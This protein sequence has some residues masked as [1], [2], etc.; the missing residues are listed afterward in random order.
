M[1]RNF[2]DDDGDFAHVLSDHMAIDSGGDLLMRMDDHM[3]M[4]MESGDLH[5]TSCWSNDEDDE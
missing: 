4:D 3:A 1:S 2:W 5:Y